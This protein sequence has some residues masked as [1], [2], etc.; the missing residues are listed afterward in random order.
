MGAFGV[1]AQMLGVPQQLGELDPQ[2]VVT[3]RS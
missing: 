3:A 1:E 2:L